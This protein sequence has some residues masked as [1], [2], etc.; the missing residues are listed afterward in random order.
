MQVNNLKYTVLLS[1]T[2]CS[3]QFTCFITCTS[4]DSQSVTQNPHS[5]WLAVGRQERLWGTGILLPQ[6]F[7]S[8]TTEVVKELTQSS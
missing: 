8:K 2:T 5:L 6:D 3:F 4:T 7:C 1:M